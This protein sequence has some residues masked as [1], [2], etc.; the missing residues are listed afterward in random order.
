[1]IVTMFDPIE[2]LIAI[3]IADHETRQGD[4]HENSERVILLIS[5]GR[6]LHGEKIS[7]R[8]TADNRNQEKG[9]Y[10]HAAQTEHVAKI[11]F[12]KTGKQKQH[13]ADNHAG[14]SRE[15][16]KFLLRRRA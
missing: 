3:D 8:D 15:E 14:F 5:D 11:I 4:G 6:A 13:E 1:M 10:A 7:S 16:I 12:R 2:D 9:G